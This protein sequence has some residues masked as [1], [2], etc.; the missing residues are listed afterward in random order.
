MRDER[1]PHQKSEEYRLS[2]E[3]YHQEEELKRAELVR[4]LEE[5]RLQGQAERKK[6]LSFTGQLLGR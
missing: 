3:Q 5:A 6:R 1:H 4:R 2:L